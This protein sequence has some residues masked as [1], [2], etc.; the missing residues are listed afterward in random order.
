MRLVKV[1][2]GS[3]EAYALY[4]Q[5]TAIFNRRDSVRF[6]DAFAQL[7]EA[8]RLDPQFAR[9]Y[10]RLASLTSIAPAYD[11]QLPEG[12]A[13]AVRFAHRA[14][15]LD[16]AL[17]EPHAALGQILFTQRRFT[18]AYAAYT[19]ALEL[20][21]DDTA[22]NLWLA[23][24][25][26][27]AGQPKESAAVLDKLL[28]NDPMLPNGLLWRGWTQLQLGEIDE[29]ERSIKRAADAGLAAVGLALAHVAQARGDVEAQREWSTQGLELFARDL[30]EGAP[31]AIAVGATG[32]AQARSEAIALIDQYVRAGPPMLSGAV[33]LALIWLGQPERALAIAQDKPTRNDTLFLPALWAP[34]GRATRS[35][36]QFSTFARRS[37][38]AELWDKNGPPDGCAKNDGGDYVCE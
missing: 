9:A 6:G 20:D 18:E 17:A 19:R 15:D 24:L 5:A 28:A 33:P 12:A 29:A 14:I 3:S 1:A 16:A 11:V 21:R 30:P 31:H 25:L 36:P 7:Q 4:L 2:T 37:G 10:A 26:S 23:T 32:D 13:G 8:I 34:V 35:A 38:L 27:C 22:A